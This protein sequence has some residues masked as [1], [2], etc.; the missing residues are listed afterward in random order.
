MGIKWIRESR[1]GVIVLDGWWL[2]SR[3]AWQELAD[4][5]VLTCAR[6]TP[7]AVLLDVR[8]A[9]FTPPAR[10]AEVLASGLAGSPLVAVLSGGEGSYRCARMVATSAVLRGSQAAAFLDEAR[11]WAWLDEQLGGD[12]R[13]GLAG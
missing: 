7:G 4:V 13:E 11:A 9:A 2:A 6:G 8:G 12:G 3:G 10:E 1:G 5:A